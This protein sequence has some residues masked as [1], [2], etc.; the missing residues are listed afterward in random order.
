M[1]YHTVPVLTFSQNSS[2]EAVNLRPVR[3]EGESFGSGEAKVYHCSRMERTAGYSR[4]SEDSGTPNTSAD[5]L[6]W[7]AA[8]CWGFIQHRKEIC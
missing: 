6:L 8:P 1:F 7:L 5:A 2:S 4:A 3:E